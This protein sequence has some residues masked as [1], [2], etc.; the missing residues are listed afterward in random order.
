MRARIVARAI[1][2]RAAQHKEG[3]CACPVPRRALVMLGG[4]ALLAA[5][6]DE[7]RG[8]VVPPRASDPIVFTA[9]PS[10]VGI[11]LTADLTGLERDLEREIPRTL[12]SIAQE[13]VVCVPSKKVD[14]ALFK[15]K[16]PKIKCDISG[17]VRRGRVRI[18]GRGRR[19]VVTI[20]VEAEVKAR[21]IAGIFKET[22][23]AAAEVSLGIA[24]DV[25]RDW[26]L[27]GDADLA[28]TWSKEPGIDFLGRR[29]TFTDKADAKLAELRAKVEAGL[30]RTLARV[31]LKPAANRGWRAA[32]TVLE[33]NERNPPVWARVRPE[34]FHFGGYSLAGKTLRMTLGIEGKLEAH[35]GTRPDPPPPGPLPPIA[36]LPVKPGHAVLKVPVV[37]NYAVLQPVLARALAKRSKRPFVLG[38]YGTV[39]ARFSDIVIYG[40]T[41]NR[42]AVGITFDATSDLRMWK[43]AKGRVWLTARPVNAANSRMVRFADLAVAGESDMLGHDLIIALANSDDLEA[44]IADALKQNFEGDFQKLKGKIDRAIAARRDGPL[45]YSV[46]LEKIDTGSIQAFGQGL[47]LPVTLHARMKAQLVKMK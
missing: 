22:G 37:S 47:Y 7:A 25:T 2:P 23:T 14:L 26:R 3:R 11:D 41:G 30:E 13:K 20:P 12:W 42:I 18:A 28:Y 31:A 29:I 33:L 40:T 34:R 27:R 39:T 38:E 32:H 36:K 21:E 35:V 19:L 8:P 6:R 45:V 24:L 44:V 9:E 10:L 43:Q 4:L 5:C 1:L 15:V 16:S 46:S 17:T